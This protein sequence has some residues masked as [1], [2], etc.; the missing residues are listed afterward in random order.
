VAIAANTQ[1]A[2]VTW[3]T[4]ES[5]EI[6]APRA[7]AAQALGSKGGFPAIAAF[8]DGGAVVAWESDGRIAVKQIR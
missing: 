7:G 8:T 5:I 1:G 6:F 3:T 4:P 2:Y